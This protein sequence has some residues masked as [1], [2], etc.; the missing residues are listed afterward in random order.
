M[1]CIWRHISYCFLVSF[2]MD[3]ACKSLQHSVSSCIDILFKKKKPEESTNKIKGSIHVR[4]DDTPLTTV[5]FDSDLCQ[6]QIPGTHT[7]C[8]INMADVKQVY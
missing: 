7:T 5:Q 3:I 4:Q 2:Q 6:R 8:V 1:V